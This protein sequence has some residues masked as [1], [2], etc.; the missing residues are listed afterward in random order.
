[1]RERRRR[2][3]RVYTRKTLGCY[4]SIVYTMSVRS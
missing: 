1:M 4:D 3:R 2:R